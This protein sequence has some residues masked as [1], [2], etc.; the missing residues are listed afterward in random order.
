MPFTKKQLVLAATF[1]VGVTSVQYAQARGDMEADPDLLSSGLNTLLKHDAE[2]GG[3]G[4]NMPARPLPADFYFAQQATSRNGQQVARVLDSAVESLMASDHLTYLQK[5]H[6]RLLGDEL[7]SLEPGKVGA[8]L[9]QLAGSQNANLGTAT[10][11]NMEQINSGLL[12]AMRQLHEDQTDTPGRFWVQGLNNG[13]RL[14]GQQGSAGLQQD[15]QGLLI[16][17]DWA[18]SPEWRVGMMGGKSASNFDTKGFRGELDSWHLGGYA[19]RQDG[20]LALRLGAIHSNHDGQNKRGVDMEF[21]DYREQLKGKYNAQSQNAFAEF[22]Y[23]M[24]KGD[25]SAE[26]FASV[27]YQ[28][29]QRGSFKE[30]GGLT[31]L[32]VGEQTQQNLNSTFGLR[33]ASVYRL[34]SQMSLKPHLSTSWKHLYGNVDSKVR[35][36]STLADKEDFNSDFTIKGTAL[37]RD[38]LALQAGLDLGLSA[39]Q[40]LSVAYTADIGSN[41]RNQGVMGQWQMGF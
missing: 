20:P 17:A 26:P 28:R 12:S 37:D 38:S 32:N 24:G 23:Q 3:Q 8:V 39:Q 40:S 30:K 14:D 34:D 10:Q 33:L 6:L 27:G 5:H 35:Q 7:A 29:Y 21:F 31:A 22:G 19:V 11:K 13:G 1:I 41:S 36:S 15:N 2:R 16:G 18:V 9:E 25:F 4:S